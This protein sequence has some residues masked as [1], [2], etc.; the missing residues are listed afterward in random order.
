MFRPD[1][2]FL[3]PILVM[4]TA[5]LSSPHLSPDPACVP[6]FWLF[7]WVSLLELSIWAKK[8]ITAWAGRPV[9]QG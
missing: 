6:E 7:A 2:M 1:C 4:E 9:N 3:S 8:F 5:I